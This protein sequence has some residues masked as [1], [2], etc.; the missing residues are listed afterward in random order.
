MGE[1]SKKYI[2]VKVSQQYELYSLYTDVLM[3]LRETENYIVAL[4]AIKGI[5]TE[6]FWEMWKEAL[7][8]FSRHGQGWKVAWQI[9]ARLREK[10]VEKMVEH[11]I[12]ERVESLLNLNSLLPRA[13][14]YGEEVVE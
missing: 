2:K 11:N 9:N 6:E 13:E 12:L 5:D 8:A 14:D 10:L 3:M 4:R 1:S 7:N